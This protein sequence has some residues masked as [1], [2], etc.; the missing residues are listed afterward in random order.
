MGSVAY[1]TGSCEDIK[2]QLLDVSGSH[3]IRL[4]ETQGTLK[5]PQWKIIVMMMLVCANMFLHISAHLASRLMAFIY[6][7]YTNN[8]IGHCFTA[9][10][11]Y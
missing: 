3:F 10:N 1:C 5:L 8:T 11:N 6:S 4:T 7:L 9:D 2:G